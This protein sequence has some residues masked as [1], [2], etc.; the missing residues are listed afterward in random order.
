MIVYKDTLYPSIQYSIGIQ[1]HLF[2]SIS[3]YLKSFTL[4]VYGCSLRKWEKVS[5][6]YAENRWVG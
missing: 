1:Y 2:G 3:F 4:V 6:D 5:L